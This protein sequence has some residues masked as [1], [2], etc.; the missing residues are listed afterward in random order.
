MFEKWFV[1]IYVISCFY[2]VTG[3]LKTVRPLDREQQSKFQLTA[4]VQDRDKPGWE[5]SSQIEILVSDLN[6][7]AP[8]FSLDSYSATLAED[9]QVG[10]LVTK[11]HATDR[12]IGKITVLNKYSH[13]MMNINQ[14]II[15]EIR[16]LYLNF[17]S[18]CQRTSR[19]GPWSP[20]SMPLTATKVSPLEITFQSICSFMFCSSELKLKRKN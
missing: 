14:K 18:H 11:V 8:R 1:N 13:F 15:D 2:S 9:V 17:Y 12:D 19:L 7:N 20:E 10:S 6:D 3:H 5:C 4:H 16:Y